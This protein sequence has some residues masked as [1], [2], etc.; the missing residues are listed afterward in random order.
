[1]RPPKRALLFVNDRD[2]IIETAL[3]HKTWIDSADPEAIREFL[4]YLHRKS[5][6][7]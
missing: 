1:M 6:S 2:G 3:D 5:G 7:L 4:E